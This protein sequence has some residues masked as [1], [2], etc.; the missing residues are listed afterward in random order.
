MEKADSNT[1]FIVELFSLERNYIFQRMHRYFTF[2]LIETLEINGIESKRVCCRGPFEDSMRKFKT[3]K[4]LK[5]S[6]KRNKNA[7]FCSQSQ[8]SL[9]FQVFSCFTIC[10]DS[11]TTFALLSIASADSKHLNLASIRSTFTIFSE[12]K[13]EFE[14]FNQP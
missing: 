13:A 9:L 11:K 7:Y 14:Y 10:I 2:H 6:W 5:N 4:F 8:V 12:N 1:N 3:L